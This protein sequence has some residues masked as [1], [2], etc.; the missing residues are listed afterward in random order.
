MRKIIIVGL[1][2]VVFSG[3]SH[4]RYI[5]RN[6]APEIQDGRVSVAIILEGTRSTNVVDNYVNEIRQDGALLA[7][8]PD[9]DCKVN[10]FLKTEEQTIEFS[11]FGKVMCQAVL[12]PMKISEV[13]Y[14]TSSYEAFEDDNKWFF[15]PLTLTMSVI[16]WPIWG[17]I[18]ILQ[19]GD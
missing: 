3:C 7:R 18:M 13:R 4:V 17:P 19:G 11:Q 12:D 16:T 8:F 1:L 10:I 15:E 14:N 9:H 2:T 6:T 5:E